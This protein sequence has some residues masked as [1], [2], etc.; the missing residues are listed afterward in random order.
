MR[1]RFGEKR[2]EFLV[3]SLLEGPGHSQVSE[4]IPG[5]IYEEFGSNLGVFVLF[6]CPILIFPRISEGLV[7][8]RWD[9]PGMVCSVNILG[10]LWMENPWNC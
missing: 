10:K 7:C 8:I 1:E 4:L 9:K 2:K 5:C 3:G 6:F